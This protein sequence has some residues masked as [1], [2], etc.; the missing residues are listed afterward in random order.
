M[1]V[2]FTMQCGCVNHR[3]PPFMGVFNFQFHFVEIMT[4][5]KLWVS[6]PLGQAVW[7]YTVAYAQLSRVKCQMSLLDVMQR[8]ALQPNG[9]GLD[10]DQPACLLAPTTPENKSR[11]AAQPRGFFQCVCHHNHI[12]ETDL[13]HC[14]ELIWKSTGITAAAQHFTFFF[15]FTSQY[16]NTV[17]Y[18]PSRII[19]HSQFDSYVTIIDYHI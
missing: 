5:N 18:C 2:F 4:E 15:Y 14:D 17:F 10:D 13:V 16:W 6:P 11:A 1:P 9:K 19:W 3:A 12:I 8:F 7:V